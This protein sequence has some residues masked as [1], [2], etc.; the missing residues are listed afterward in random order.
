MED[1]QVDEVRRVD[2]SAGSKV[3]RLDSHGG[4]PD[5]IGGGPDAYRQT[6]ERIEQ[7]LRARLD[8]E[9]Q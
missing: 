5:P 7:A 4:I 6:A 3:V 1:F 9:L 8:K 2:P